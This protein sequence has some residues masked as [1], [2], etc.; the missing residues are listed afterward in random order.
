MGNDQATCAECLENAELHAAIVCVSRT[1]KLHKKQCKI[2]DRFMILTKEN[3]FKNE[4][5]I[6]LF[7]DNFKF[8]LDRKYL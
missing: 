6:W 4:Y 2:V 1:I 8:L 5:S 7:L 3:E